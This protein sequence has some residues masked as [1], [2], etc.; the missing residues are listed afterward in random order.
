MPKGYT[1]NVFIPMRSPNVGAKQPGAGAS[2]ITWILK[3]ASPG[4]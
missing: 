4:F 1:I 2:Q 3:Y